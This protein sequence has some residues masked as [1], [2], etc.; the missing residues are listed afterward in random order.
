MG[1]KEPDLRD[2]RCFVDDE[3]V[4]DDVFVEMDLEWKSNIDVEI[5]LEVLGKDVSSLV[6]NF[7]E[8][9]LAK[10]FTMVVGVEDVSIKGTVQVA[11]R[12]LLYRLPIVQ[13]MQIGFTEMPEFDFTPTVEGGPLG[14][15]L[16][17][18]LPS[19]K[20]WLK[21]TVNEAIWMPYVLPEHYF[22][23]MEDH[24]PDLQRPLGVLHCRIIEA[25]HIPR[26]DM[27]GHAD[28]FVECYVRHSQRNKTKVISGKH[29]QWE[30]EVFVMPVHSKQHQKLKFALWDYDSVSPN[31]EIGRCEIAILDIPEGETKDLWLEVVNDSEEEQQAAKNGERG[32]QYSRGER[33]LRALAKPVAGHTTKKTQLHVR[34]QWRSWDDEETEFIMKAMKHGVKKTVMSQDGQKFDSNFTNMLMSGAIHVTVQQCKGLDVHGLLQ[35]PSV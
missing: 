10:L 18:L 15:T 34:V 35:R 2:V 19:V 7:L 31:D 4:M 24:A 3:D 12:P 26:M 1:E 33:A 14:S 21:S 13:A 25:E 20:S 9:Q 30:D 16:N 6:P 5:A 27:F 32:L 8:E 22:Y 17:A 29:P 23:P 11:M 28:T